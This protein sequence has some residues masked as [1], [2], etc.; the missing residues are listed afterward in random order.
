MSH[1]NYPAVQPY[2]ESILVAYIKTEKSWLQEILSYITTIYLAP[3]N[4]CP[5]DLFLNT[6]NMTLRYIPNTSVISTGTLAQKMFT[7]A[8]HTVTQHIDRMGYRLSGKPITTLLTGIIFQ[9]VSV[10]T[11]QVPKGGQP[12]VLMRDRQTMGGYPL[13]G[14]VAYLDIPLLAQSL[15]GT[16]IH[17][18]PVKIQEVEAELTLYKQF[19]NVSL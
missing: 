8:P 11:I 17:F 15:P 7:S 14:C 16:N 6:K 2:R 12:I 13:M 19:F 1:N 4:K 9:D 5:L 3:K 18:M 10:G